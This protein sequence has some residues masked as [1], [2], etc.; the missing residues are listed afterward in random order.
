[1]S[2]VT[3]AGNVSSSTSVSSIPGDLD[4]NMANM[5]LN[6]MPPPTPS[7]SGN[8]TSNRKDNLR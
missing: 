8:T 3:S 2:G 5:T 6:Q 4:T 1:M 7:G